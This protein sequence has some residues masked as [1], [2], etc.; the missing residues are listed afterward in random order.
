MTDWL[1]DRKN[2][3]VTF[4][5]TNLISDTEIQLTEKTNVTYSDRNDTVVELDSGSVF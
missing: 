3:K 2:S 4:K 1:W 5:G